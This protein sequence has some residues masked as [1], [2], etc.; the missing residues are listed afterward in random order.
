VRI[1]RDGNPDPSLSVS[2]MGRPPV[3]IGTHGRIDFHHARSG[4]VRARTRIR[5]VDGVLRAVTRWGANEV[6]ACTRL[7]VAVRDRARRGEGEISPQ[8]RLVPATQMWLADLDRSELAIS[9]RQLYRAAARLYLIP[10]QPRC[11]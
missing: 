7:R 8:T 10:Q 2:C 5:D 4:R 3:P 9:T 1:I 11:K 6:D